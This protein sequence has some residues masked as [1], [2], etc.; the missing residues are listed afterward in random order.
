[1]PPL[2]FHQKG[3]D[4]AGVIVV[5]YFSNLPKSLQ[6]GDILP[7]WQSR[8]KFLSAVS[9]CSGRSVFL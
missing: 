7:L 2:M 5:Q 4:K 6:F 8:M 9:A 1:M 3:L